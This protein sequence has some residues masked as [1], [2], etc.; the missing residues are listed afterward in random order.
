VLLDGRPV[1]GLAAGEDVADGAVTVRDERL[2]R[3][4]SLPEVAE[5]ELTLRLAPGVSA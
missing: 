4:V 2:Y 5:M 3:L 1:R